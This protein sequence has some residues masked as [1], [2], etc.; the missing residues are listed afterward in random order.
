MLTRQSSSSVF[1]FQLA[2]TFEQLVDVEDPRIGLL[3][4]FSRLVTS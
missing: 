4:L 2:L 1:F 3:W